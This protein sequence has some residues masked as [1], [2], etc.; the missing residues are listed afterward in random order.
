MDNYLK[1]S[2]SN[3]RI[4]YGAFTINKGLRHDLIKAVL[5]SGRYS[6]TLIKEP[7]PFK[8][9]DPLKIRP[10]PNKKISPCSLMYEGAG[11]DD[12]LIADVRGASAPS[13]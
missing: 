10:Y 6:L 9:T 13:T 7:V 4:G 2:V 5:Y 12:V 8:L 1:K 3:H 11:G